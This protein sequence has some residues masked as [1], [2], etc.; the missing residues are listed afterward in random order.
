MFTGIV[1][2]IGQITNVVHENGLMHLEI[3]SPFSKDLHV[4]Q[5]VAHNGMCLTITKNENGKHY[6]TLVP[7]S[8]AYT[9][10]D[11]WKKGSYVNLERCLRF[12]DRLDG[13]FVT[14]HVDGILNVNKIIHTSNESVDLLLQIPEDK[15]HLVIHK[16]SICIEGISLT[17][18]EVYDNMLRV[19]II[20]HTF[21]KTNLQY[22]NEND[23]V[24][25]EYDILGKYMHRFYS[26]FH[27]PNC[28]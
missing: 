13:H 20:P 5:S 19:S 16:G 27:K 7:E 24:H 23:K 2:C 4:D 1:E 21:R 25:V 14:G 8:L 9:H 17:V 26:I 6:V 28:S 22:L 11:K 15:K 3:M 12:Y 18:A 10:L